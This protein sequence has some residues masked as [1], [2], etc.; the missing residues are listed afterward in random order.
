MTASSDTSMCLPILPIVPFC[1]FKHVVPDED[2]DNFI[3]YIHDTRGAIQNCRFTV[4]NPVL[5]IHVA[6]GR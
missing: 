6:G 1:P 4:A 2:V 3:N 5:Q